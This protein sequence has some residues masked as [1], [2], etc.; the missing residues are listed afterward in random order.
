MAVGRTICLK[1]SWITSLHVLVT[2]LAECLQLSSHMTLSSKVVLSSRFTTSVT[3]SSSDITGK[4]DTTTW[5]SVGR[6]CLVTSYIFR[7][8]KRVGMQELGPRFTLKL[9][10]L[11]QGTFD[12]KFG[13]YIWIHK[14]RYWTCRISLDVKAM[15]FCFVAAQRNGHQ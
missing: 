7:S 12:T 5:H 11:Q 3:T 1:W 8:E 6:E 10:S 13:Q 9:R 4:E 15:V 2:Q 14:V